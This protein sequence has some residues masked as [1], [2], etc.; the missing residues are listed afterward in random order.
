M[1]PGLPVFASI[2]EALLRSG[3]MDSGPASDEDTAVMDPILALYRNNLA[4]WECEDEAR[5][6]DLDDAL[7]AAAKRDIDLLNKSR[8][9]YIEEI[10]RMIFK[11]IKPQP[12]APLAT[13]SPGLAIDR[14]SVLVIRLASTEASATTETVEAGLYAER[15]P[16]LRAQL[17]A[18]GESIDWLLADVANGIRSFCPYESFKIYRSAVPAEDV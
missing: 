6:N 5:R 9:V 4:Q 13:E 14:L 18:L 8:H 16:R 17:D 11:L 3:G 7:L 10:D 12:D 2:V 1:M 15:V